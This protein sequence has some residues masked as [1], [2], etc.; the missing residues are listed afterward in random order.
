M[1]T[2]Y[3]EIPDRLATD[4]SL[5]EQHEWLTQHLARR[6][7]IKGLAV[8]TAGI[9]LPSLWM[10]SARADERTVVRGRHLA[11]GA[12]PRTEM[13]VGF[14][15]DSSFAKARVSATAGSGSVRSA[16]A[17]V[18][19]VRGS[20][21]RYCHAMLTG[22]Q[23]DT[24]YG[25]QVLMDGQVTSRGSFKTAP[26][27]HSPFRFTAFGDQATGPVPTR[28]LS[29]VNSLDP[30]LHLMCGDL[31]YADST[32][33]GG[34][35][36]AFKPALWDTWLNMNDA[37]A[38][39]LPWM[40]VPGNHEM[41]PGYPLHGYAGFLGR[42]W[43]GGSSPVNVPVATTFRIG[44]VGFVG[45]DSNDVSYELPANRGWTGGAQTSWLEQTLAQLR[46]DGSGLDFVVVFMHHGPY[47]TSN[48]H[49]SEGGVR[50]AWV[51]L[52]DKYSVDLVISGHNH[53][54][55]RTLPLRAGTVTGA[56]NS[57]VDSSQGTTYVTAGGGGADL[58]KLPL[59]IP[60]ADKTR[61]N[62]AGGQTVE[63]EEWSI[64]TK[65]GDHAVLCVDV[66]PAAAGARPT[67]VLRAIDAAGTVVDSAEL[68]RPAPGT[69]SGQTPWL[70]G[71]SAA[72]AVAIGGAAAIV[73]MR[74]KRGQPPE[75]PTESGLLSTTE[76]G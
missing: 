67:L 51:P 59:F 32:G 48:A 3:G 29:R 65:T 76:E 28:L 18:N 36:D 68:S 58:G 64:G 42:V 6:T 43:P 10:Q 11:Y 46:A 45:L 54:Y 72:A 31:C 24:D 63:T 23:A 22:L 15:V 25:Y 49:A 7:V 50:E 56:S 20:S 5:A 44:S 47:S 73:G 53:R 69:G 14:A 26:S 62:I 66:S 57:T 2:P 34:P 55:E 75:V 21:A 37:V 1:I 71:G 38:G 9:A 13:I 19:M 39:R 40:S 8:A 35:G 12:D 33:T 61:V 74:H 41:E 52:F 4:M 16:D 70:V 27:T 30:R 17:Q 60:Y